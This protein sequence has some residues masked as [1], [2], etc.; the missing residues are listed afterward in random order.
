MVSDRYQ[1]PKQVREA[2]CAAQSGLAELARRG[3]AVDQ[4]P[5]WT[6][7]LRALID[8]V[9]E[10]RPVG[11]DGRHGEKHTRTCGCDGHT[12][13]WGIIFWGHS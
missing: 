7:T 5:H 3:M 13:A 12:G 4:V 11:P 6:E 10:A 2:L 1:Y 8:Q 9:D